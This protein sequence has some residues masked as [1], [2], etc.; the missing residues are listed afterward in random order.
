MPEQLLKM[1]GMPG[2]KGVEFY[3]D[4]EIVDSTLR[5][6]STGKDPAIIL[7]RLDFP[8]NAKIVV[9]LDI[10]CP[11]ESEFLKVYYLTSR[12]QKYS[13]ER[14]VAQITQQG[15]NRI[16]ITISEKGLV[17]RLRL[18]PGNAPG[19]YIIHEL[20]VRAEKNKA[21]A[22]SIETI[23]EELE[24]VEESKRDCLL[25]VNNLG[26]SY[27]L[28]KG[29][30]SR[31]RFWALEDVSFKLYRGETLGIIGRNG[32]GKSTLLRTLAGVMSPDRGSINIYA[33][34]TSLLS[35]AVGFI[36]Y[37]S[38]RENAILSG[39]FLGISKRFIIGKLEEI[40]E[41]AELDEFIDQPI[42]TYSSGMVGRLAF[43]VVL[44][45]NP[46]VLLI[47]EV[48]SVGDTAFREKSFAMMKERFTDKAIVLVSHAPAQIKKL[49]KRAIWI[50][51]GYISADG[52]TDTVLKE[53][54]EY[55]KTLGS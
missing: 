11:G 8:A 46:D 42:S 51:D 52:D 4:L 40:I 47:D 53:Y 36:P 19:E 12:I 31:K 29:M 54:S 43:S 38:G 24:P 2:V 39:M 6:R 22:K 7:P 3:R 17:G 27:L 18:D 28:K 37:L 44:Q 23:P 15:R 30:F 10:T 26:L 25:E 32:A 55:L 45:L 20:T 9:D 49:C 13:E 41:F 16:S 14:H 50:K 5:L 21:P 35:L 48:T 34:R 1:N 33:E